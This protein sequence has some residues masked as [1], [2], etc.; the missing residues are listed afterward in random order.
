M[1]LSARVWKWVICALHVHALV[2]MHII[3]HSRG[4]EVCLLSLFYH[5]ISP[6]HYSGLT[7]FLS[8]GQW[9]VKYSM[10]SMELTM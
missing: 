10:T 3:P 1:L 5:V 4:D 8:T 2:G 7:S 9:M 6:D